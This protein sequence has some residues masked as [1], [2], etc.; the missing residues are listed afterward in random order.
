MS[1]DRLRA[2]L[3]GATRGPWL[4]AHTA[5]TG[6]PVIIQE[7]GGSPSPME[8]TH[9]YGDKRQFHG[10]AMIDMTPADHALIVESVNALPALL[11]VADAARGVLY[12]PV[13]SVGIQ[14]A[15][16]ARDRLATALAAL[17]KEGE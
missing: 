13:E 11:A 15:A 10:D 1:L 4:M 14:V 5:S 8:I 16:N 7:R 6:G 2:A 12:A 9:Y 3:A 17:D